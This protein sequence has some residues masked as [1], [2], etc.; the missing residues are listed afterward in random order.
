MSVNKQPS[1]EIDRS[2]TLQRYI[3]QA[4]KDVQLTLLMTSIQA[5]AKHCTHSRLVV[6]SLTTANAW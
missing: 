4:T 6:L 5:R 3:V 2:L 1:Q